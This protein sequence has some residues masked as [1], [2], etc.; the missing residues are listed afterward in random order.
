[1]FERNYYSIGAPRT[2]YATKEVNVHN[3]PTADSAR[4]LK[5]LEREAE[6]KIE[7]SIKVDNNTFKGLL[8]KRQDYASNEIIWFFRFELNSRRFEFEVNV[9]AGAPKEEH[10][11]KL[12]EKLLHELGGAILQNLFKNIEL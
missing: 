4:L 2:E 11:E 9:W 5:E 6:K 3:A 7:Q 1:M 8:H 10:I 12:R